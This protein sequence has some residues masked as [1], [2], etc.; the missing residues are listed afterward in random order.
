MPYMKG[1]TKERYK[2][3]IR[4]FCLLFGCFGL[5]YGVISMFDLCTE[6]WIGIAMGVL[7]TL[8]YEVGHVWYVRMKRPVKIWENHDTMIGMIS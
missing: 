4:D 7:G 3:S 1:L 6:W 5:G 8:F 2:N